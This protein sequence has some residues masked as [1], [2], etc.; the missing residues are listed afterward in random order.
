[1]QKRRLGVLGTPVWDTIWT[2]DDVERGAPLESWGGITYALVGA[3]AAC[4]PGWEVVPLVKVGRDRE[5]A[6]RDFLAALPNYAVGPSLV[7]V[8]EAS[9]RVE[10]RYRTAGDRDEIQSGRLPGWTWDDLAPHVAGLDALVVNFISGGE[11][12]LE[13]AERLSAEFHGPL[14]ADLH[15]LFLSP[16]GDHAR[17]HRPLPHWERWAAC[18]DVVQLNED[19]IGT[20]AGSGEETRAETLRRFPLHGPR[21]AALTL[22]PDGVAWAA[23]DG[24]AD[25]VFAWPVSRGEPSVSVSSGLVPP[26]SG[27]CAG[28]PTGAGDVW[29]VS[30]FCGLLAGLPCEEAMRAAH[31]AAARKMGYRGASGLYPHMAGDGGERG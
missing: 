22:G 14:Y 2:L 23:D 30:F 26:P 28:D 1:M 27:A 19:E 9:N 6:L 5:T 3:A 21:L 12:G 25:D 18:F 8:D 7:P 29:G 4:P 20:L 11:M 15:S 16:P 24:A 10:L 31:S 13:T 17:H